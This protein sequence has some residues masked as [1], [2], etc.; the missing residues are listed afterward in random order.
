M[1][2][3]IYFSIILIFLSILTT[4][5]ISC[6]KEEDKNNNGTN[7]NTQNGELFYKEDFSEW[8][9]VTQ[10][11]VSYEKPAGAWWS[12]LNTL[13][14]IGG[15]ATLTKTTDAYKG[16]Y[17]AK[18]QTTKWGSDL[19]VP[20]MLVSGH[21]D[22]NLP[23]G[24]NLVVGKPYNVKPTK[25]SGFYK[26]FPVDNDSLVILI[27]LTKFNPDKN[28]KDTIG[29]AE[30]VHGYEVA[31]YSPF[32]LIIE[33]KSQE[34]PDS[35]HIIFMSSIKGATMQGNHGSTLYVDDLLLSFD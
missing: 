3:T 28:M 5:T 20:G 29:G 32:E 13:A 17:A 16:S 9:T 22:K 21:F 24:E 34:T 35:I 19:T 33:Y 10:G 4:I 23:I 27:A 14:T 7:N 12:S 26:Y 30:M 2:K 1:H 18:L 6:E 15:P 25:F 11:E 31:Q 8:M